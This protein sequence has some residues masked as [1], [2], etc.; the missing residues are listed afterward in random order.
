MEESL[1]CMKQVLEEM[2]TSQ[3]YIESMNVS[4]SE[5]KLI[6]GKIILDK[7]NIHEL[8]LI[9][10]S[11][12][13]TLNIN[14]TSQHFYTSDVPI[15]TKAHLEDPIISMS[16]LK[17][18]GVEAFFPISPQILLV[19]VDG[20][21][22]KHMVL[23]ERKYNIITDVANVDYYNSL[24]VMLSNRFIYSDNGNFSLIHKMAKK[25]SDIYE[26]GNSTELLWG[27]NIYHPRN[28]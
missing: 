22:H 10:N 14:K 23:N 9:F 16:G 2:N 7:E 3:E 1:D 13:W 28:K 12:T 26:R 17:S 21:Y 11:L 20:D 8:A 6:H 18:K 25:N 5:L 27:G 19:M 24:S 4:K 15:G